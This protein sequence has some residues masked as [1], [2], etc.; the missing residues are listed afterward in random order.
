MLEADPE[1]LSH[2]RWI[3]LDDNIWKEKFERIFA[4]ILF[5]TFCVEGKIMLDIITCNNDV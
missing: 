2:L 3:A 4:T 5:Q 1:I